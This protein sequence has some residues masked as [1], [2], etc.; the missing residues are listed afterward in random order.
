MRLPEDADTQRTIHL[1]SEQK[2][3]E[4]QEQ[5]ATAGEQC[6]LERSLSPPPQPVLSREKRKMRVCVCV[7]ACVLTLCLCLRDFDHIGQLLLSGR[8]EEMSEMHPCVSNILHCSCAYFRFA[9]RFRPQIC[10]AGPS[11]WTCPSAR[12]AWGTWTESGASCPAKT[13][14]LHVAKHG[15]TKRKY[16]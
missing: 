5:C 6:A 11:Q 9:L 2:L 16:L 3:K 1:S 8:A 4:P 14:I 7:R 12:W 10:P 13:C 15:Y